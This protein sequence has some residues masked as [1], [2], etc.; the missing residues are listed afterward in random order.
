MNI[1]VFPSYEANKPVRL[2]D[3]HGQA[4]SFPSTLELFT[5]D[6]M[7]KISIISVFVEE[8]YCKTKGF[9]LCVKQFDFFA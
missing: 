6:H 4:E 8:L 9:Y 3:G 2:T 7:Q 1:L 5:R